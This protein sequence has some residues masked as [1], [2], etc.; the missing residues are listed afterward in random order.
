MILAQ[1][2][3]SYELRWWVLQPPRPLQLA[4]TT[5]AAV[6]NNPV[7]TRVF[8]ATPPQVSFH[9]STTHSLDD[10]LACIG[11]IKSTLPSD[12]KPSCKYKR[13]DLIC[14]VR[15]SSPAL[16]FKASGAQPGVPTSNP[17]IL[18]SSKPVCPVPECGSVWY[19]CAPDPSVGQIDNG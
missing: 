13:V 17:S 5:T 8:S 19:W 3:W 14:A 10:F 7:T 4:V 16:S 11:W 9:I 1:M 15:C 6:S 12:S 2:F 18:V